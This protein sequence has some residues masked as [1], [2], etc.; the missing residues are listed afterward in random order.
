MKNKKIK[1]EQI[2]KGEY[3]FTFRKD[4]EVVRKS[5]EGISKIREAGNRE[6]KW[7]ELQMSG[8][9]ASCQRD[10]GNWDDWELGGMTGGR[11]L[12][13]LVS[14]STR[15]LEPVKNVEGETKEKDRGGEE[16]KEKKGPLLKTER[17]VTEG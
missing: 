1:K 17:T 14:L 12:V 15:L 4:T 10:D 11:N 2:K 13:T 8:P 5:A 16:E 7:E 9:V 6:R 3:T